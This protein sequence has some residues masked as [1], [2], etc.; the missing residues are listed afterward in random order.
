MPKGG[1]LLTRVRNA[2]FLSIPAQRLK[3]WSV[4]LEIPGFFVNVSVN[5]QVA[6][7]TKILRLPAE[8]KYL[9]LRS[10]CIFSEQHFLL[11]EKMLGQFEVLHS[12]FVLL[13]IP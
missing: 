9:S 12:R 8:H 10:S 11:E 7:S 3:P 2:L 1:S 5:S 13:R 6:K 4:S